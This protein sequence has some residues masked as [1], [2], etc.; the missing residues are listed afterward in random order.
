MQKNLLINLLS[1]GD[2]SHCFGE[3]SNQWFLLCIYDVD[4]NDGRWI[5]SFNLFNFA[6]SGV[7]YFALE[8]QS[9]SVKSHSRLEGKIQLDAL[10]QS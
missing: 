2:I 9:P 8:V 10:L 6:S 1:L 5:L 4:S 3:I 7:A